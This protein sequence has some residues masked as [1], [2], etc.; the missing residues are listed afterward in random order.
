MA[1]NA[2]LSYSR[3]TP[4]SALPT[5]AGSLTSRFTKGWKQRG[6]TT[7]SRWWGVAIATPR[8]RR[9]RISGAECEISKR[10]MPS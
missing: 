1:D 5:S 10:R 2:V 3:G 7:A 4:Q 9:W 8:I 6:R